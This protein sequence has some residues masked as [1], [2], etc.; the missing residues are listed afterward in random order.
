MLQQFDVGDIHAETFDETF[1]LA[2]V[3]FTTSCFDKK[4]LL[5]LEEMAEFEEI[6]SKDFK[7]IIA[8]EILRTENTSHFNH[9]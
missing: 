1:A 8:A 7:F 6:L 9:F 5:V 2:L 3:E 4:Q